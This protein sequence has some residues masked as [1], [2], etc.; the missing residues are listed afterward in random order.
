LGSGEYLFWQAELL[1]ERLQPRI[2]ANQIE[3]WIRKVSTEPY[4]SKSS[5]AFPRIETKPTLPQ[6]DMNIGNRGEAFSADLDRPRSQTKARKACQ[7][8][9][10][11]TTQLEAT[12]SKLR[13]IET[14]AKSVHFL[15]ESVRKHLEAKSGK[16]RQ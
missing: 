15:R 9:A 10:K 7:I 3:F 4:G 11:Y 16:T 12:Q 2:A 14:R 5:H 1:A 13:Q 8:F 6:P